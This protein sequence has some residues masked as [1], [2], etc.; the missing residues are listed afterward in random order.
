MKSTTA[1]PST[2][3]TAPPP[4]SAF[5][6]VTNCLLGPAAELALGLTG[7]IPSPPWPGLGV[8][9]AGPTL[10]LGRL[11]SDGAG[12]SSGSL[13]VSCG[14]RGVSAARAA[15]FIQLSSMGP[16][17]DVSSRSTSSRERSSNPGYELSLDDELCAAWREV[18]ELQGAMLSGRKPYGD[19]RYASER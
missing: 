6:S 17:A 9:A 18:A 7:L 4:R 12:V 2:I 14:A 3:G 11:S 5:N 8:A 15:R 13:L 10:P 19:N 16:K 1:T